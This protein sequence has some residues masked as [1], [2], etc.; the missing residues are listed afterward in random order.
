MLATEPFTR[1]IN[2]ALRYLAFAFHKSPDNVVES[3]SSN[4]TITTNY[5]KKIGLFSLFNYVIIYLIN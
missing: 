3:S 1:S 2:R 4:I 5:Y